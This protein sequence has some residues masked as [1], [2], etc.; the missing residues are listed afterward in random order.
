[1]E[2]EE[3]LPM[4]LAES[5][6][7]L[8][9]LNLAVV[10]IEERPD[11]RETIDEIFRIAHSLKGMSAT[12][13]FAGIAALTH[14][15]ED[16]FELLRQRTGG[17][18]RKVIDVVLAC[19]DA[20]EGAVEA[21]DETGAEKLAAEPLLERL[22]GLIRARTPAQAA[23]KQGGEEPPSDLFQR[24]DGRRV[25][26][27]CV[28]LD[29]EAPMPA[30]RA[31]MVLNALEAHGE[32]LHSTPSES[33]V[34]AFAGRR[35]DAW[36]ASDAAEPVV[37]AAL[38]A[39]ADVAGVPEVTAVTEPREAEVVQIADAPGSAAAG[40]PAPPRKRSSTVRV[41]AERLDALMHAMGELVVYRTHVEALA[42]GAQVP[43]LVAAMQD[44]TR[45][46]QALQAMVMQVRMIPVEAV[47]LRFPRLV[48][49]LSSKLDKQVDLVLTGQETELDRTVIDALGDPIV[50]LVRNAL[51]H[52]LEPVDERVAAGKSPTGTIE[53]AARHAGSSI[54]IS[55]RDDGRGIDPGRV[56]RK[57]CERGLIA[58]AEIA[59]V[60]HARAAELLFTAGF[61]TSD[62]ATDISG[63]GVGMDAVRSAIRGLG[64]EATLQAQPSG[65]TVAEIR[66]PLTLAIMSALLVQ[67]GGLPFAIPLDR[68]QRTIR[69]ADH[70]VR[71]VAGRRMLVMGD[72]VLPLRDL[73]EAVGHPPV[74]GQDHAVVVRAAER[75]IAL[76]VELLIGQRELV[77]RA[78]PAAVS[79]RPALSGGA[80]LAD[81]QIALIV[82]CDAL[83]TPEPAGEA[84]PIAA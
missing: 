61:S 30:V 60:D 57:A 55:V 45:T 56:A 78:L 47:F 63:R 79:E 16:V 46:S 77:A 74:A 58:S 66:L 37:V 43:G 18:E 68:V 41:D 42:A 6:E 10:R 12:M 39:V 3:Y 52:G 1:M 72:R 75:D 65:G 15:M 67:S 71:S 2:L 9:H 7:H 69:L 81:G 36:V 19:L 29:E 70:A 4:F 8:E 50:H 17:L 26:R 40:P 31:F 14:K 49:D 59:S 44:L 73:G 22:D 62:T 84:S 54:V 23:A 51:D 24:A 11:D 5:R 20:L 13:G 33:E 82:D 80:V 53:I 28:H 34:D 27:V 76:G 48:R 64:G 83:T 25:L 38:A 21:I 35:I 32:L